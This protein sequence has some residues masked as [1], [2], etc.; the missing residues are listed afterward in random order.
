MQ[1]NHVRCSALIGSEIEK[2]RER[3]SN[4]HALAWGRHIG[5]VGSDAILS[6]SLRFESV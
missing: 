4:E 2:Q 5:S 3:E 6:F 1:E